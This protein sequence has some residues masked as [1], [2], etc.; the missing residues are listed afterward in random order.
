[1][2][3]VVLSLTALRDLALI[4]SAG[5]D[6]LSADIANAF[7]AVITQATAL[8]DPVFAGVN[9]P[10]GRLQLEILEQDIDL[11][12]EQQLA[13]IG[14]KLGVAAGFNALDGD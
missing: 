10:S 14:A 13:N 7:A 1:L 11:I 3:H 8:E 2:R 6:S 5:D 12:R 4:L 9:D